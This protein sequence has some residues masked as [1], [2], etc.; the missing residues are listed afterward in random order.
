MPFRY[1]FVKIRVNSW[2]KKQIEGIV[3]RTANHE[4]PRIHTN[5]AFRYAFVK[6]RVNSWLKKN[7]VAIVGIRGNS[8][9]L[10]VEETENSIIILC[11]TTFFVNLYDFLTIKSGSIKEKV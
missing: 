3:L 10:V 11:M 4:F 1:P 7:T 5:Y 2:L 6:I 8:C 9:G